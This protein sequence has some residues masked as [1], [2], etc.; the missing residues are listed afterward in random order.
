[1]C[2][3]AKWTLEPA[4]TSVPSAR[5]LLAATLQEWGVDERDPCFE[6]RD[7]LLLVASELLTNAVKVSRGPVTLSCEGHR[8]RVELV[9]GDDNDAPAVPQA[10]GP[11][12]P[13]GRGLAIVDRLSAAWGQRRSGSAKEVWA[14]MPVGP[15]SVLASGCTAPRA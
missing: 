11:E 10:P 9:V 3:R 14:R 15:G 5:Q 2:H 12:A 7:D 8:D 4:A 1:M 6:V 13:S